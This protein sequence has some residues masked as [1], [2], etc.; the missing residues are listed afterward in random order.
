MTPLAISARLIQATRLA[1]IL[2]RDV[3][4]EAGLQ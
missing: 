4:A 1:M 3:S 2:D